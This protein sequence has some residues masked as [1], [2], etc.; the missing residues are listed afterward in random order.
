MLDFI[1]CTMRHFSL[2]II[3]F[4]SLALVAA[5]KNGHYDGLDGKKAKTL[6]DQVCTIANKGYSGLSYDNL[7]DAFK[8][9]DVYPGTTKIWDMYGNCSFTAG[10]KKCGS[11]KNECDCYNREHSVPKSWFGGSTSKGI[12]TDLFHLVPTDGKVNGM[13]SNHPFGETNHSDYA[14]AGNKLGKSDFTGYT[15]VGTVFEPADEY[16]GDFARGY[17]GIRVK[18]SSTNIT[19]SEGG[20]MFTSTCTSASGY[21][22]SKYSIALLMKWHREDPVS[23]KE[24]A[25]NDA[26]EKKQGNRNPFIDYPYLAEFFWGEKKDQK[27]NFDYLVS[28]YDPDFEDYP[29]GWNE[30]APTDIDAIYAQPAEEPCLECG[31]KVMIDGE[32]YIRQGEA[33]YNIFGQK[34]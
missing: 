34:Y 16:K 23:D 11:Y 5:P 33:L 31:R 2:F 8:T 30:G 1:I 10:Q 15:N 19:Q 3:L 32:I 9:T 7:W 21:G 13:R 26:I 6:F 24:R 25:R 28:A 14:Y 12:G 22:L 18:W 20:T 17:F 4:S 27:L 29:N